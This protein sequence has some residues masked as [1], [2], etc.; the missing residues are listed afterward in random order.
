MFRVISG[1]SVFATRMQRLNRRGWS[2]SKRSSPHGFKGG[3]PMSLLTP[4]G[5]DNRIMANAP[6]Q[7]A[8]LTLRA[9]A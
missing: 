7:R 5:G 6:V 4:D 3:N 8:A 9:A 2:C 1:N